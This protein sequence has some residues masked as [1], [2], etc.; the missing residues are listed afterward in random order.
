MTLLVR[1]TTTHVPHPTKGQPG[2]QC[3]WCSAA[4]QCRCMLYWNDATLPVHLGDCHGQKDHSKP[5]Q[6]QKSP[7]LLL[8]AL[9]QMHVYKAHCWSCRKKALKVMRNPSS[10]LNSPLQISKLP[11]RNPF[12][13]MGV[14]S[15]TQKTIWKYRNL[16][17]PKGMR[18]D[19]EGSLTGR[20]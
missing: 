20:L 17:E 13:S 8:L 14:H 11:E 5:I 4:L 2:A 6:V 1:T 7:C 19:R 10:S 3:C 15:F 18:G 12:P 9:T 16:V